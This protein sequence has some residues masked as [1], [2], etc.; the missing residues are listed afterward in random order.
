M[1]LPEFNDQIAK[2]SSQIALIMI[3]LITVGLLYAAITNLKLDSTFETLFP[4]D[5]E[6]T[7]LFFEHRREF[8]TENDFV[9]LGI[10]NRGGVIDN[11]FRRK[12]DSLI[13][14]L[15]KIKNVINVVSPFSA[16]SSI[17]NAENLISSDSNSIAL[18]IKT[19][20]ELSNLECTKL[21]EH[22]QE[23]VGQTEFGKIHLAG[24][25]IGQSGYLKLMQS[26]MSFFFRLSIIF[27]LLFLFSI[28]RSFWGVAIPISIILI[29]VIW[30]LGIIALTGEPI[31]LILT[32]LPTIIF[33]VGISDVIH[34]VSRFIEEKNSGKSKLECIKLSFRD[35]GWA[36]FLTSVTTSIGFLALL[37]SDVI[38]IRTFGLYTSI[39]VMITYLV[40][41]IV[42]PSSLVLFKTYSYRNAKKL[43]WKK[44]LDN[45]FLFTIRNPRLILLSS[46]T[47]IVISVYF[48]SKIHQN[49]Y[50]LEDLKT[51]NPIKVDFTFFENE[52]SGVR[53][54]EMNV[55]VVDTTKN[56]L[57]QDVIS[58]LEKLESY[59][60]N[61]YGVKNVTSPSSLAYLTTA[62]S[63]F[64]GKLNLSLALNKSNSTIN[65]LS[66]S[67]LKTGRIKGMVGDW[68]SRYFLKR[69]ND[70]E[71]FIRENIN[72]N[73]INPKQTGT[74][75]LLDKNNSRIATNMIKGLVFAFITISI[76]MA[77]MF[78]SL[79]MLIIAMVPNIFPLIILGGLLGLTGQE[80][81]V[82]MSIIF[83]IAFGISVDDT[84]HFLSRLKIEMSKGVN[85]ILA[86]RRTYLSTGK[87]IFLTTLV[88][89]SGFVILMF[90][91]FF[92]MYYLGFLVSIS[93]IIAL[94]A[95]L[96]LL[97][98]LLL[99]LYPRLKT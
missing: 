50:I 26:D 65:T 39:S 15:Y 14:K 38:P 82:S 27:L 80:F 8:G 20:N 43:D 22:L 31:N 87:A 24:R 93:L 72:T 53:P 7:K 48:I 52:F 58:E 84:I 35:V 17:L 3:F 57:H 11:I 89:S 55:K 36:T 91:N 19:E 34:F 97:P 92:T 29:S 99:M 74:A 79:K 16:N 88:L 90:S 46:L 42:L 77:M 37:F 5:D 73:L 64:Q 86:M 28:Y 47:L 67:T 2:K 1:K 94:V 10:N 63:P 96:Y 98:V 95:D 44:F 12:V 41:I 4:K 45:N 18:Y 21:S 23:L 83:T 62:G 60:I 32:I 40:T 76:L 30:V 6:E 70:L 75:Y 68:G 71:N 56:L 13:N 51:D 61:T 69:N 85:L 59:L 54:F 9:L 33:V 78:R 25:C 49:D 66:D 81:K